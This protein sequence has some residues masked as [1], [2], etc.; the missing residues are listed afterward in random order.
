[1]KHLLHRPEQEVLVAGYLGRVVP[2]ERAESIDTL[3][4]MG[5][6]LVRIVASDGFV[7]RLSADGLYLGRSYLEWHRWERWRD[8]YQSLQNRAALSRDRE[9]GRVL[10]R[11]SKQAYRRAVE[12]LKR[13]TPEVAKEV[14]RCT[15][16]N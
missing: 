7:V 2:S 6:V 4:A 5:F 14:G 3:G 10:A 13:A 1:M 11:R 12:A 16:T 8:L 15:A 9:R